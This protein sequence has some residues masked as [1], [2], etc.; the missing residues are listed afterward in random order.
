MLTTYVIQNFLIATFLKS[1]KLVKS[2]ILYMYIH[3]LTQYTQNISIL[4]Y[5]QHKIYFKINM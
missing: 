3:N 2:Y 1:K 5:N 4:T